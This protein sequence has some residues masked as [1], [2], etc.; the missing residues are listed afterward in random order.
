[1]KV[2][3]DI[4]NAMQLYRFGPLV[5]MTGPMRRVQLDQRY[6]PCVTISRTS[7]K[8]MASTHIGIVHCEATG[9]SLKDAFESLKEVVAKELSS[10][11]S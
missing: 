9:K 5:N 10:C 3:H 2:L 8:W 7:D 11:G 4:L 6:H 1:M